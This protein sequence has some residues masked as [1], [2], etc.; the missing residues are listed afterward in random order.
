MP[1]SNK[2]MIK[3]L[4]NALNMQGARLLYY[5]AQ[6]YSNEKNMPVTVYKLDKAVW[7]PGRQHNKHIKLFQ[8][9]SQIQVVLYLRDFW[10]LWNGWEL[11]TDNETWN[12]IRE[13][14]DFGPDFTLVDGKW[15]R[16]DGFDR[17]EEN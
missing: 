12:T 3:K 4:Q 17:E 16:I 9:T 5:T 2:Q 6:F 1:A 10:Y 7:D 8:S 13:K 15:C 14:C 11:P